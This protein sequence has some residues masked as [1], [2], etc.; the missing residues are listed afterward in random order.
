MQHLARGPCR[1]RGRGVQGI[2]Q[3]GMAHVRHVD[4]D[5][6]R[7]PRM[8]AYGHQRKILAR[9]APEHTPVAV[10][11]LAA[12]VLRDHGHLDL[13]GR[14]AAQR[15]PAGARLRRHALHQ[16]QIF[17]VDFPPGKGF[18][19]AQAGRL[20]QGHEQEA[21]GILVQ[22]MDHAGAQ[23][24]LFPQTREVVQQALDKR[25]F[26][27][28]RTGMDRQ[29]RRFVAQQ[30]MI[31]LPE[32]VHRFV[33]GAE[34]VGRIGQI[35]ADL[36][37]GL[38]LEGGRGDRHPV[39]AAGTGRD[40]TLHGRP[41]K[42]R[43]QAAQGLVQPLPHQSARHTEIQLTRAFPAHQRPPRTVMLFTRSPKVVVRYRLRSSL[44]GVM[45]LTTA[46][47]MTKRSL[48]LAPSTVRTPQ[49]LWKMAGRPL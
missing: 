35:E 15:F 23:A 8:D 47:P 7:A 22:A 9:T 41:G 40:G 28:G 33:F 34:L 27:A 32:D 18:T 3:Q 49:T 11:R 2:A 36:L 46:R 44:P 12:P 42:L 4:A 13:G 16:G 24:F 21:T 48:S 1:H 26:G 20:V 5:L 6:M 14:M 17:L 43:Q 30:Q 19:H 38:E 25:V 37:A 31:V 10:G 45:E 39:D 29:A